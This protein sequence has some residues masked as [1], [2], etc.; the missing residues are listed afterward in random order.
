MS[1]FSAYALKC[2]LI[3]FQCDDCAQVRLNDQ[4]L[5]ILCHYIE[6]PMD[7]VRNKYLAGFFYLPSN[8]SWF[9]RVCGGYL[10]RKGLSVEDYKDA[11]LSGSIP[12]DEVGIML[13]SMTFHVHFGVYFK[14]S[15][16]CTNRDAN[17]ERW[18]GMFLYAGNMKFLDTNKGD[19]D[20]DYCHELMGLNAFGE[21]VGITPKKKSDNET[22]SD[23]V[24][25]TSISSQ[26]DDPTD[27]DYHPNSSRAKSLKRRKDF[28][29]KTLS[30]RRSLLGQSEKSTASRAKSAKSPV[31]VGGKK[32]AKSTVG[33]G[34]K[35]SAKSPVGVGANKSAKSTVV[36]P[37]S[38]RPTTPPPASPRPVTPAG[39]PRP[40]TPPPESP[41]P[42]KTPA[43]SPRPTTP[44]PAS[45]RLVTPAGSPRPSTPPPESPRPDNTPAVSPRPSTPPPESPRPDKTPAGSP[46]P[47][48]PPPDSP[49]P[50]NT[51][52]VSPRPAT[53]PASPSRSVTPPASPQQHQQQDNLEVTDEQSEK[54]TSEVYNLRPRNSV[55]EKSKDFSDQDGK[56]SDE[57]NTTQQAPGNLNVTVHTLK[58]HRKKDRVFR[59]DSCSQT[60]PLVKD[61][62]KH[63]KTD[64]PQHEFKCSQCDKTYSS[65]NAQMRHERGHAGMPFSCSDCDYTCMFSYELKNHV[66]RHTGRGLYPC[67]YRGCQKQF[68]TKKG[69]IQHAQVHDDEQYT[70]DICGKPGF[71]TK[72][73]LRQ[74][75]K[76]HNKGFIARCGLTYKHP[77]GRSLH[78]KNC[79]QCKLKKKEKKKK[80]QRDEE[81]T[82]SSSESD[83]NDSSSDSSSSNSTSSSSS[84]RSRSSRESVAAGT[85][86]ERDSDED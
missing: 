11:L 77:T 70:C 82:S 6:C 33:V 61:L 28:Q 25:E 27:L 29:N 40:S 63:Y 12:F 72:G 57:E 73:Y 41:R 45:P 20:Y 66:K 18:N 34:G 23:V 36:T 83:E 53:P 71:N 30:K 68:T 51:P 42:D 9:T 4:T 76:R 17:I 5:H 2:T 10:R 74:H 19:V 22:S 86:S 38:P 59:C 79:D 43:G 50:D 69:M 7:I 52:A 37:A 80:L 14:E 62:N 3:L 84:G 85:T 35:K 55:S 65:R 16:W 44:P 47:S 8:Y 58:K 24:K 48:T 15:F 32:S 49:R 54:S 64:H 26:A 60:F 67:T 46:R 56:K 78:Q 31:G 75:K 39:S 1:Y 81:S 21:P 13:F